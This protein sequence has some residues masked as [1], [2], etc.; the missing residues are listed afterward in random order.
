MTRQKGRISLG[1]FLKGMTRIRSRLRS[2]N[3]LLKEYSSL[4][5]TI[6]LA[7]ALSLLG[8]TLWTSLLTKDAV[9]IAQRGFVHATAPFWKVDVHGETLS[10]SISS[11]T[12]GVRLI[13]ARVEYPFH[14]VQAAGIAEHQD[15][16]PRGGFPMKEMA[17]PG[18]LWNLWPM[19]NSI[20]Q[21]YR[22]NLCPNREKLTEM[23]NG[24]PAF[25]F[26]A[27]GVDMPVLIEFVYVVRGMKTRLHSREIY[28]VRFDVGLGW[29]GTE[30]DDVR[31]DFKSILFDRILDANE[32]AEA[33]LLV[34][35]ESASWPSSEPETP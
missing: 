17:Y 27:D 7:A 8:I 13:E 22:S 3:K 12:E 26:G 30:Y 2:V 20:T 25:F 18:R 21:L 6:A 11:D 4:R 10:A 33:A 35:L 14:I 5:D 34:A 23:Q 1:R 29:N 15:S 31:V 24:Y 28:E 32:K 19:R 9:Q 16:I